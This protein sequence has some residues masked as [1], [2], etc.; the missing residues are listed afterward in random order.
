VE[1]MGCFTHA[2]LGE[3][4]NDCQSGTTEVL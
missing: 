4:R 3:F 2:I 1:P